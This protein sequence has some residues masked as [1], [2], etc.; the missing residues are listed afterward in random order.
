[1][2]VYRI[3]AGQGSAW[4][5]HEHGAH[6]L[7]PAVVGDSHHCDFSRPREIGQVALHLGRRHRFP[8]STD[9][10]LHPPD[11]GIEAIGIHLGQIA[12][13]EP[14]IVGERLGGGFGI[15]EVAVEHER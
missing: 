2:G 6:H 12:S 4:S 11:D 7:A 9:H 13:A 3:G 14:T 5:Q 8:A 15:V 10:V 1:M